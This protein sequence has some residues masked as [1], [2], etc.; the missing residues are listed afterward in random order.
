MLTQLVSSIFFFFFPDPL[1]VYKLVSLFFLDYFHFNLLIYLFNI[2]IYIGF[3]DNIY[4]VGFGFPREKN[5][6]LIRPNSSLRSQPCLDH[7]SRQ[8][9][10]VRVQFFSYFVDYM[11]SETY[12]HVHG[13]PVIGSPQVRWV[14]HLPHIHKENES[15]I[16]F[17]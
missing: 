3:L 4:L 10:G 17:V 6:K 5:K 13:S 1:F 8:A 14:A 2:Y 11:K 15:C 7:L 9:S 16:T 12:L